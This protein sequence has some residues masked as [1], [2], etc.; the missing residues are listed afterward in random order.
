MDEQKNL[1]A[2]NANTEL[3]EPTKCEDGGGS[4]NWSSTTSGRRD[5][6][7]LFRRLGRRSDGCDEIQR[8][9]AP[10]RHRSRDCTSSVG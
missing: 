1:Q 10:R 7:G 8:R 2:E 3:P 4:S 5:L 6:V 9:I